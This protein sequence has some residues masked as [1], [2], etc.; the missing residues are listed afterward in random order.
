MGKDTAKI[1]SFAVNVGML[2]TSVSNDRHL[3]EMCFGEDAILNL[4]TSLGKIREII[5]DN[6]MKETE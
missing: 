2:I 4:V 6:E 3:L 1:C 5:L